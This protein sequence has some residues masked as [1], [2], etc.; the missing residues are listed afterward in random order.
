MQNLRTSV[1]LVSIFL[2]ASGT[3]AGEERRVELPFAQ[4]M[5][6]L[7]EN[8]LQVR[9]S[10]LDPR[11]AGAAV[12]SAAGA[13]DPELF[14]SFRRSDSST[15]LS[16]RSSVAAG[17]RSSVESESYDFNAGVSG[18]TGLGTEYRFEVRDGW[19]ADSFS[20][21][22]FE[23]VSFTGV[24][25]RQPLLRG[26]G[27]G[28]RLAL[29]VAL[30]DRT[31]SEQRF[32]TFLSDALNEY[33]AAWWDLVSS[34]GALEV[35]R[36]SLQLAETLLE[37]NRKKLEAGV[38]SR[39]E[40]VQ[41][42]SAAAS[43]RE[44]LL[45][46]EKALQASERRM[47]ELI[48]SDA[49]AMK[50]D[51]LVPVG[52]ASLRPASGPPGDAISS[53][54]SSR[55]DYMELKTAIEKER[56][57]LKYAANQAWP[58]VDLEASYGFNGLGDSFTNSFGNMDSNPEWS[59]G[60]LFSYPLGNRAAR[61]RLESARLQTTQALLRLKRLEQEIVLRVSAALKQIET[62]SKRLEAADE[63]VRLA[64]ETLAAEEKK[65]EAGRS[66]TFNVLSI[67]EDL[68]LARLKRL[69]AVSDY[70]TS[71]VA[72]YREKGTLLDELGVRITDL[73][74]VE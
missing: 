32:R 41:A 14:G 48:T 23:Y 72:F 30:K 55:A 25:V 28:E 70:N 31:A 65:L 73:E 17:G 7:L 71:L 34:A 60:V 74:E 11:I 26:F 18:T 3:A 19:T 6:M 52:G 13:F 21:F 50:D 49:Y 36:E 45:V 9:A 47:K 59:V 27:D 5:R 2:A 43:R 61:G 68:L 16:S 24:T 54:L 10:K 66:T 44:D 35:R 39:L 56:I 4:G 63:A 33:A 29:N 40:L 51:E 15:P 1:L 37:V 69:D 64:E 22:E 58:E 62:D 42:A 53:A 12:K 20:G 67:Q 38:L 46:A 57:L 8:N